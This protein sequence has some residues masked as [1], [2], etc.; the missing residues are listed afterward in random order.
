MLRSL[1]P[2][3]V[4]A[5]V[6]A[7]ASGCSDDEPPGDPDPTESPTSSE[8]STGSPTASPTDTS[9]PSPSAEPAAGVEV[10]LERLS[11]RAPEGWEVAPE[12][13]PYSAQVTKGSS[14]IYVQQLQ[15]F[16]GGELSVDQLARLRIRN[17]PY[18]TSP[19]ILEPVSIL[20]QDW[21]HLAGQT[22]E[23]TYTE[24]FGTNIDGLALLI[25][26]S[27]NRATSAGEREQVVD[28]VLASVAF[29]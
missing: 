14:N 27:F 19:K 23:V 21:Y 3:A 10:R 24:D 26:M 12:G 25:S 18:L 29:E 16:G 11:I 9:T 22:D 2:A 13:D 1:G 5:L 20:G 6:L 4:L 17:G 7:L 15:D 8:S 28:S